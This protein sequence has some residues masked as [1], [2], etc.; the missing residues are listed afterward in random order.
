MIWGGIEGVKR[1]REKREEKSP[2]IPLFP[3]V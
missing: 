2:P 3:V 1:R